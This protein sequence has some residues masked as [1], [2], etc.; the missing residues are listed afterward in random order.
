MKWII[1][2]L[3]NQNFEKLHSIDNQYILLLNNECIYLQIIHSTDLSRIISEFNLYSFSK[4]LFLM[5]YIRPLEIILDKKTTELVLLFH[6]NITQLDFLWPNRGQKSFK[7]LNEWYILAWCIALISF[8][9]SIDP[10][11]LYSSFSSKLDVDKMRL[12]SIWLPVCI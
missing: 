9:I 12:W 1:V 3:N 5:V 11:I 10:H 7:V 2:E 6:K 8:I 4:I